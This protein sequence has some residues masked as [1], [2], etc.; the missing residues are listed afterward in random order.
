[1][2]HPERWRSAVGYAVLLSVTLTVVVTG[3]VVGSRKTPVIDTAGT[4][5]VEGT[6]CLGTTIDLSQSGSFVT[7]GPPATEHP[8][9]ESS[10]GPVGGTLRLYG[11]TL[12]GSAIC[13]DGT[14]A[15]IEARV[16]TDAGTIS[17]SVGAEELR[18]TRQTTENSTF[19]AGRDRD[20]EETL[21]RLMLA[22]AAV[23]LA[24]RLMGS[25]V[26]R[27]GQ[28]RVMGEVLAGILL[29]P[30][31]VGAV[32]P[33]VQSYLFPEDIRELLRGAADIG[34]VF[35]MFLVGLELDPSQLRGHAHQVAFISHASI[36]VPMA[37]GISIALPLFNLLGPS[38]DFA[39]YALF[40]GIAM[41][42][43]AFPVLARILLERRM[44][45]STLGTMAIGAA[46]VDDLTA[47]LLIAL[48]SGAAA[49]TIGPTSNVVLSL[50]GVLALVALFCAFMGVVVRRGLGR[51]AVSYDEAGHVPGGW[52]AAILVGVLVAAYV[53]VQI[54]VAGIFGA[55]VVGLI[56]PRRA[57]LTTEISGRIEDFVTMV[58]LPLFFV[59]AGL[60]TQVGLIRGSLL[61]M[62]TIGIF[63]VAVSCKWFGAMGASRYVGLRW[64]E[65]AA[66]GALM[67]T[68]GLTEL[69]VLNIGLDSGVLTPTLYTMLVIMALGT[70]FMTG[71]ALRAID[72]AGAF[73][74]APEDEVDE[75]E[76]QAPRAGAPRPDRSV[77]IATMDLTNLDGL[78]QIALPLALSMPDRE[79]IL[80][81]FVEP[82]RSA[83]GITKGQQLL[84]RASDLLAERRRDAVSQGLWARSAAMLSTHPGPDL[85]RLATQEDVD[86]VVLDGSRP[87][88]RSG[89]PSGAVGEVLATASCDVALSI[90]SGSHEPIGADRPVAVA[91]GGADHDWAALEL[92]AWIAAS[93]GAPLEL[94]GVEAD[95]AHGVR[96]A[97]QLLASAALVVQQLADMPVRPRLFTPGRHGLLEASAGCGLLILGLSDRWREEGLGE[98]RT[99][100]A[101]ALPAPLVFVRRGRDRGVLAAR[102]ESTGFTWSRTR[103]QS[104]TPS[105][106]PLPR[107]T[108]RE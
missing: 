73:A 22:I 40:M 63:I 1:M 67:N 37:V 81:A 30:T 91:F 26:T 79:L 12:A 16:D 35:Y 7:V 31:L 15:L 100:V 76:A 28:P 27:I 59:V 41:S 87:L 14:S 99:A 55:F 57:G 6:T 101:S 72:P 95:L 105:G 64:R 66:M 39:P 17:G 25:L 36:C 49:A 97:S 92:G 107:P 51:L 38:T 89:P 56:M 20:P 88:L 3:L 5:S 29:G 74:K 11:E 106:L 18:A 50:M 85:I 43:T 69:I 52:L 98:M 4:F 53:A 84:E 62:I 93:R 13:V 60:N 96:D 70:T 45:S 34:L 42:I 10:E 9:G 2:S 47:W 68:R 82:N 44:L 75:A 94:L 54:G 90:S 48:A 32:A 102:D 61:W 33:G 71:P 8:V 21:G 108:T 83:T 65:S 78:M 104:G 80:A 19:K 103:G 23:I 86:L 77:L 46:A 58:L 24:A